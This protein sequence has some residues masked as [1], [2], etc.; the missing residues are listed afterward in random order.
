MQQAILTFPMVVGPLVSKCGA[1]MSARDADGVWEEMLFAPLFDVHCPP[2]L[3]RLVDV[4]VERHF[5][6]WKAPD[7]LQW[8]KTQTAAVLRQLEADPSLAASYALVRETVLGAPSL[9]NH[10][11]LSDFNDTIA[12]IPQDEL[13]DVAG[14]FGTVTACMYVS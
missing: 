13:R 1:N 6:L 5:S 3:R 4:F 11:A 14:R 2:S 12:D 9:Y 10:I 8:L 7:A